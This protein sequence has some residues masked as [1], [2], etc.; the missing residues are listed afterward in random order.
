MRKFD[1][2]NVVSLI[3][4]H[5]TFR[6][7]HIVMEFAEKCAPLSCAFPDPPVLHI[8]TLLLFL[9]HFMSVI[10]FWFE[11]QCQHACCAEA[12]CL[13]TCGS[14]A[15]WMSKPHLS[16]LDRS[17]HTLAVLS[18]CTF[19]QSEV[20]CLAPSL[21]QIAAGA[22]H[23]QSHSCCHRDIKLENVLFFSACELKLVDFGL[24]GEMKAH[25]SQLSMICGSLLYVSGAA[26]SFSVNVFECSGYARQT[27]IILTAAMIEI[28]HKVWDLLW[29][30][31]CFT[32]R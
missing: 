1:H 12:R 22:L 23:I 30:K 16:S 6:G 4:T 13:R 5:T 20:S 32:T 3:D 14:S 10:P 18:G 24:A 28:L 7:L 2:P 21:V 17:V 27:S 29:L 11:V 8:H 9:D 19:P 26:G 25:N 31:T 15:N